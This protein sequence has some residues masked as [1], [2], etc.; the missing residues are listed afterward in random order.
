MSRTGATAAVFQQEN[1]NEIVSGEFS[2][3]YKTYIR[4]PLNTRMFYSILN[5]LLS[6]KVD[7]G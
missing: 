5:H 4:C 2:Q 6:L 3:A 7:N 1:R